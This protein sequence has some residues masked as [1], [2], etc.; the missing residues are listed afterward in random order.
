MDNKNFEIDNEIKQ[1][2]ERENYV[3]YLRPTIE[4]RSNNNIATPK[5][6]TPASSNKRALSVTYDP[7]KSYT[8]SQKIA[9]DGIDLNYDYLLSAIGLL[10]ILLIVTFIFDLFLI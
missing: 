4:T 2:E 3:K 10:R 6:E 8:Q 7:Y 9:T 5:I 1:D